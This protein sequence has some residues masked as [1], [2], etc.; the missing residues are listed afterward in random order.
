MDASALE[1]RIL[2]LEISSRS[3]DN[4]LTFWIVLIVVGVA[5]EVITV[6]MEYRSELHEYLRGTIRS[7]EKP[8]IWMFALNL[9][10]ATLVA[11]G[12]AGE[13]SI[14][15]QAG[16]VETNLRNANMELS[17]LFET[18][19]AE[20]NL[21]TEKL[22]SRILQA[23][24]PRELNEVQA[25]RITKKL[26]KLAGVQVDVFTFALGNPWTKTE[27]EESMRLARAILR[28]LTAARMDAAGWVAGGGA[29][30][31]SAS[32]VVV[33]ISPS[34]PRDLVIPAE[35]MEALKPEV[36][37][38]PEF[39]L[40]GLDLE[41]YCPSIKPLDASRPN[42]HKPN[43]VIRIIIGRSIPPILT[44]EILGIDQPPK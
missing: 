4:W 39:D 28:A 11:I 23:F 2:S 19:A 24:G 41:A 20:A 33:G 21:K 26:S 29:C 32:N 18:Q 44:P 16:S 30:V 10:G 8:K 38:F 14:H 43:A 17:V 3:L 13:F 15:V 6:V 40:S 5:V 25:E 31:G 12:V 7:P 9:L 34:G 27:Y 37:T 35:I 1:S 22:R 36:P 42:K